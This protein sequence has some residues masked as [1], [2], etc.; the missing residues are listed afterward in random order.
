ML[1]WP[2]MWHA[3][4]TFILGDPAMPNSTSVGLPLLIRGLEDFFTWRTPLQLYKDSAWSPSSLQLMSFC[5]VGKPTAGSFLTDWWAVQII[6][7]SWIMPVHPGASPARIARW[8]VSSPIRIGPRIQLWHSSQRMCI[9][10]GT[11]LKGK[12]PCLRSRCYD[13]SHPNLK[14]VVFPSFDWHE[15]YPISSKLRLY[16]LVMWVYLEPQSSALLASRWP[17]SY[18]LV[19]LQVNCVPISSFLAKL[20]DAKSDP[21]L[22]HVP[23]H[24]FLPGDIRHPTTSKFEK[25]DHLHLCVSSTKEVAPLPLSAYIE[26]AIQGSQCFPRIPTSEYV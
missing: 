9:T 1:P 2:I 26:Q 12:M 24:E 25:S 21:T 4:M 15:N 20:I 17:S 7:L 8:K 18:V 11:Q 16:N 3:F 5:G 23:I 22:K 19:V 6:I 10:W 13:L 14:H